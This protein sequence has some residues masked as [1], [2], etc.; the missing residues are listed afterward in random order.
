MFF[1]SGTLTKQ[2][3]WQKPVQPG[4]KC[5]ILGGACAMGF[6]QVFYLVQRQDR[7]CLCLMW[8]VRA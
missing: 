2:T 3:Y 8:F 6:M 7:P 5:D 1:S 4:C